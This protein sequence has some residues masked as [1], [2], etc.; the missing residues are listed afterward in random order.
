MNGYS[1]GLGYKQII[2]GGWYGFGEVN[3]AMFGNASLNK[4]K[5]G[6]IYVSTTGS[7]KAN[8]MNV[9]VGLGYRF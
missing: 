6:E 9:L 5:F 2:S 4:S 7:F 8:S 3:Y 1:L